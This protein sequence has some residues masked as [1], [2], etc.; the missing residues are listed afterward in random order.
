M[1]GSIVSRISMI[2]ACGLAFSA[3]RAVE[4]PAPTLTPDVVVEG[5]SIR[6]L[7]ADVKKTERRF[8]SLYGKYNQNT[9]QRISCDDD[10]ATGTRFTKR[11]CTTRAAENATAQ[12]A[13]DFVA[14]ADLNTSTTTTQ[15]G[16]PVGATRASPAEPV[17]NAPQRY[18]AEVSSVDLKDPRDTYRQ[19]LEKLM[20]AH[21]DLRKAFEEYAQARAA[22]QAAEN[23]NRAPN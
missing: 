20:A 10:A 23:G 8:Q 12:A 16:L 5:K 4:A 13:Q 11:K 22:L 2:L 17:A 19:N 9:Q 14:T 1:K 3:A 6:E 7:R 18:V 15:T 21:P